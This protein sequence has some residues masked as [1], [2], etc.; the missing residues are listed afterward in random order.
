MYERGDVTPFGQ[1][2]SY[3]YMKEVWNY[4]KEKCKFDEKRKQVDEFNDENKWRKRGLCMMP[5][6][7]GSGYNWSCS[8]KRRLSSRFT[9]MTAVSLFIRAALIWDRA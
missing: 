7:Y 3:C 9:P 6:K 2:L 4:L 8:N 5:V 1:A